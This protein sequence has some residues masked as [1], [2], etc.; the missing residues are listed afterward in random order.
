[1]GQR[2]G[3]LDAVFLDLEDSH[4]PMHVG[5]LLTFETKAESSRRPGICGMLETIEAR[6]PL[7]PRCRQRLVAVPLAMG[8]PVWVDDPAFDIR[9]HLF[10]VQLPAPGTR[11]QLLELVAKLHSSCLRRGRPLWEMHLIH[12]LEDGRTAL[13]AKLHHA[14]VD[15]VSALELGMVLLDLDPEGALS[16]LVPAGVPPGP[17]PAPADLVAEATREALETMAGV[18]VRGMR[19]APSLVRGAL[20]GFASGNVTTS[21]GK[22]FRLAPSGPLNGPVGAGRRI[23]CVRLPLGEIKEVKNRLGASVNDVVLATIGEA[24]SEYLGHRRAAAEGLRYRVLV[25]VS[26]RAESDK[27]FGN[28]VS[29][30]VVDLPVGPMDA[31]RRLWVVMQEMAA[32]KRGARAG[33]TEELLAASALAPAPLHALASRFGIGN[34]RMVNMIV[35]NVPGVQLPVYAAGSRTLEMYPLLPLAPNNRMVVCALSYNN[36]LNIG[37]VADRAAIPDIAVFE[38]GILNGFARL[39][40]TSA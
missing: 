39:K 38:Q 34:Q 3:A 22:F 10:E 17:V 8:R 31:G 29:A 14:M 28:Q 7:L 37:V 25:P 36:E 16:P 5:G 21:V 2:L 13:Y 6:L 32:N 30:V 9:N 26:V 20:N 11:A 35:S 4:R 12:G 1:M 40:A 23:A 18:G 19:A 24:V 27:S 15:G 33:A